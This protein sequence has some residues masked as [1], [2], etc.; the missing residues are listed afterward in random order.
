VDGRNVADWSWD[1]ANATAT[2]P[3][4]AHSIRDRV[5]VEWR[6]MQAE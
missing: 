2:I 4:P 3:V 6:A 1:A 5:T